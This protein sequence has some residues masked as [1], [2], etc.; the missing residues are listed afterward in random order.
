MR[1]G[2]VSNKYHISTD[3]IYYYINYGLIVPPKNTGGQYVFDDNTLKEL[4]FVL[5]LKKLDFSLRT[6]HKIISLYR[7]SNLADKQ[8]VDDLK[9]IY[10]HQIKILEENKIRIEQAQASLENKISDLDVHLKEISSDIGLPLS[11]L[12]CLCCPV[13]HKELT[14]SN[15][16][17]NQKYIFRGDLS[18]NCGYHAH[19]ADGILHTPNMNISKYDKPDLVRELY[20]DLPPEL[21]SLFQ[22]SYNWMTEK[23][24]HAKPSGRVL[25]ETYVNA[26]FFL[27]NHQHILPKDTMI[28]VID[29]F[30][31]TLRVYKELIERQK[32]GL[33]ILYIADA[34]LEPP[35]KPRTVDIN[36][37]FF[38]LNEH[39]FYHHTFWL[40]HLSAYLKND[41][42][43]LGTYFYFEH[44]HKSM[45]TL[46]KE[47]PESYTNNFSKQYFLKSIRSGFDI[48]DSEELGYT[49]DS[50]E[51]LGFS[52]HIKGEKMHLFSYL[53]RKTD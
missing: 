24:L 21:I 23:L 19:I 17:M 26:W 6:I 30:P 22:R 25:L 3:N 7:V 46:L 9:N 12:S 44:G 16:H 2:Q 37:D 35:L 33:D 51:N 52:F 28:I 4:E 38:A 48:L 1:I 39:N 42:L 32:C 11:M 15:V 43:A 14:L 18:C 27:H 10:R 50:G 36:I 31:E 20:K 53:A 45:Q 13:C 41:A 34:G 5:D 8:D 49:T 47:Y 29:K 40:D